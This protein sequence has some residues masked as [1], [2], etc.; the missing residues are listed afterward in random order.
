MDLES[1]KTFV[2]ALSVAEMKAALN[3]NGQKPPSRK[4]ELVIAFASG[5]K[6]PLW[7]WD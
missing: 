5:I 6:D 4:A 2:A 7:S 1:L 3:A